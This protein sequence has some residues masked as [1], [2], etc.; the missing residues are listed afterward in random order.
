MFTQTA[1]SRCVL[2]LALLLACWAIFAAVPAPITI[3]D[4]S[5]QLMARDWS[6]GRGLT[7]WNGYEE[8]PSPELQL[9]VPGNASQIAAHGGRLVSQY[10]QPYAVLAA[11][12]Q[13][14]SPG[15]PD[16]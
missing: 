12:P 2:A 4:V 1:A 11:P 3:D 13:A 9:I 6:A 10:P 8:H 5:Y 7:I 16:I 15:V 14:N